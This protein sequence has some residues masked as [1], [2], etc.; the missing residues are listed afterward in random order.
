MEVFMRLYDQDTFDT[1][2][3]EHLNSW[4]RDKSYHMQG[5]ELGAFCS[6][7]SGQLYVVGLNLWAHRYTTY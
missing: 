6:L 5:M 4:Q 7:R 1:G 3:I 2:L